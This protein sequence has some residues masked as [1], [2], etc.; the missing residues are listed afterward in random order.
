MYPLSSHSGNGKKFAESS[1]GENQGS[2]P[3]FDGTS[4]A[5]A[6]WKR[7]RC[8]WLLQEK[9]CAVLRR[10]KNIVICLKAPKGAPTK[11]SPG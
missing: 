5:G 7:S 2:K 10:Y 6:A 8:H 3:T 4:Y 11:S 9:K 1:V